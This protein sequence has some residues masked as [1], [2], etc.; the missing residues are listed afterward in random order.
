MKKKKKKNTE[1]LSVR[2]VRRSISATAREGPNQLHHLPK[3]KM[4]VVH[5][6]RL[7]CVF[8]ILYWLGKSLHSRGSSLRRT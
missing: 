5:G 2:G 1:A 3:M 6:S 4:N 8:A 7:L